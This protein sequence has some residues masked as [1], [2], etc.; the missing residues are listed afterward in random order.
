MLNPNADPNDLDRRRASSSCCGYDRL[1]GLG[2]GWPN[3][4]E[5]G[6]LKLYLQDVTNRW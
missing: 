1:R 3:V 2:P 4:L 6:P 5:S